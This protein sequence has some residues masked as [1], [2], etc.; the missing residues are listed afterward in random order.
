MNKLTQAQRDLTPCFIAK[1]PTCGCI[2]FVAVDLPEYAKD[3]ARSVAQCMRDGL[4]IEKTTVIDF[5][6]GRAGK[7]G[8]DHNKAKEAKQRSLELEANPHE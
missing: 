8:C 3:N 1:S 7:F 2:A 5:R 4:I 6:E